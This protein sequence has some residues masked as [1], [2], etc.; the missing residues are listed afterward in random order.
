MTIATIPARSMPSITCCA[1]EVTSIPEFKG[2]CTSVIVAAVRDRVIPMT[3]P[4]IPHRPRPA[5][6]APKPARYRRHVA[7]GSGIASYLSG[8]AQAEPSENPLGLT[9]EA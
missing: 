6:G 3:Y 9:P 7:D 2:D 5:T 4:V 1:V 8:K